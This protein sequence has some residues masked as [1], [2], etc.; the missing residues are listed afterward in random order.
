MSSA[1]NCR[2]HLKSLCIDWHSEANSE[3]FQ[4]IL[5]NFPCTLLNVSS[6][7]ASQAACMGTPLTH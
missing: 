4:Q 6:D 2:R 1:E 3:Q 7:R 5:E